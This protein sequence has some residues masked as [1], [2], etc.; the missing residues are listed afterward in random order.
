MFDDIEER[1]GEYSRGTQNE[2]L[3]SGSEERFLIRLEELL[4]SRKYGAIRH[5]IGLRRDHLKINKVNNGN[6]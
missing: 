2:I 1:L 5:L 4:G 3:A 6:T